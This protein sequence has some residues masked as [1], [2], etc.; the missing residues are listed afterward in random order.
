[1]KRPAPV[2]LSLLAIMQDEASIVPRWVAGIRR[3]PDAVDEIVVVDGGSVDGTVAALEAEGICA[4]VRPLVGDFAAQRNF[5]VSLCRGE[6]IFEL[7]ADEIPSA[8]LLAGLRQI[9]ADADGSQVDVV[10]VA[11]LNFHDGVLQPGPGADGLDYQYRLH[12]RHCVWHGR[13]HEEV[14]GHLGRVEKALRDGHFIEHR[15]SAARFA[16]RNAMYAR[17]AP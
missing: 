11:R 14:V 3:I 8:P 12:R 6:W 17:L 13:V 15:K 2:R 4:T 5:G 9:A 10:G 7:D 1:M 16:E